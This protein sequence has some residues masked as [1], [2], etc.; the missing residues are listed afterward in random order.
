MDPVPQRT[1]LLEILGPR[2]SVSRVTF[3]FWDFKPA[4]SGMP[5]WAA[6]PQ[7]WDHHACARPASFDLP[8][9]LQDP[10]WKTRRTPLL[11]SCTVSSSSLSSAWWT[12]SRWWIAYAA[13][14]RRFVFLSVF[15][16][17]WNR[18]VPQKLST[19]LLLLLDVT[20]TKLGGNGL[21]ELQVESRKLKA[22]SFFWIIEAELPL[23]FH[24]RQEFDS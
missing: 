22:F 9:V 17:E 14:W 7:G 18:R 19:W 20:R 6:T 16:G 10:F 4:L 21:K 5:A 3:I 12:L 2:V 11:Q 8:P 15:S 24:T 23:P 13:P 1:F